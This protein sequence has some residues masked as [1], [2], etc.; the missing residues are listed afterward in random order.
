MSSLGSP[1]DQQGGDGTVRPSGDAFADL[2]HVF[3]R[4]VTVS[5]SARTERKVAMSL[6]WPGN[7]RDLAA[8]LSRSLGGG[9][10]R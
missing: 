4:D 1:Q 2:D 6:V 3:T 5:T 8:A 9:A 7:R 10:G